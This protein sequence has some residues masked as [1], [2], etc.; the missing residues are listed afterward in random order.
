VNSCY[1]LDVTDNSANKLSTPYWT[2]IQI[3]R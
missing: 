1:R 3:V 2:F